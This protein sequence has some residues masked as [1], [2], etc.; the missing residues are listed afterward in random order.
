MKKLLLFFMILIA[1]AQ[2][3]TYNPETETSFYLLEFHKLTEAPAPN[4]NLTDSIQVH[5]GDTLVVRFYQPHYR[6]TEPQPAYEDVLPYTEIFYDTLFNSPSIYSEYIEPPTYIKLRPEWREPASMI[7]IEKIIDLSIGYYEYYI[8]TYDIN[9]LN[10]TRGFPIRFEVFGET[11]APEK[12][13]VT[14]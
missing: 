10:T 7:Q 4:A 8:Y 9:G 13:I 5:I 11:T 3:Q 12:I 1:L 6:A 14:P 2:S